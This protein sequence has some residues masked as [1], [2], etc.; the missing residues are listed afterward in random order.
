M[1]DR[2]GARSLV[3]RLR[4]ESAEGFDAFGPD[5]TPT[6]NI[7]DEAAD[8]LAQ[9][10]ARA[11]HAERELIAESIRLLNEK[12]EAV[13]RV[14]AQWDARWATLETQMKFWLD[15]AEKAVRDKQE[16]PEFWRVRRDSYRI[17]LAEMQRVA[18]EQE[19]R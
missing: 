12:T 17:V 14:R 1:S 19:T 6:A 4:Q 5:F 13:T 8:A 3:E 9:W 16:L 11:L 15:V 2:S 10:E 7:L 18:A